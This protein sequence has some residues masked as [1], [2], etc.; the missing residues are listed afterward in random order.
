MKRI[1]VFLI[2]VTLLSACHNF[3]S[4]PQPDP[5]HVTDGPGLFSGEDGAFTI[6]TPL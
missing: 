3:E 2:S 5:D 1:L 4:L 6:E